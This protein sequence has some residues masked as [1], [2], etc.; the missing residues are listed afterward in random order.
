MSASLEQNE[1]GSRTIGFFITVNT[2][3]DSLPIQLE[4]LIWS[5]CNT[6]N[7]HYRASSTPC[8]TKSSHIEY[9]R[10]SFPGVCSG[11]VAVVEDEGDYDSVL[12]GERLAR[13]ERRSGNQERRGDVCL[14]WCVII[15]HIF[16][17]IQQQF[18]H[19]RLYFPWVASRSLHVMDLQ[20]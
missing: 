7:V 8:H 13:H 9:H 4:R 19:V 2:Y 3:M 15:L 20:C 12:T 10:S 5:P 11:S 17:S 6:H 14:E 1:D 18:Y 16:S